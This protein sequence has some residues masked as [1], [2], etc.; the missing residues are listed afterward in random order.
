[1]SPVK[2][3]LV[4]VQPISAAQPGRRRSLQAAA[5]WAWPWPLPFTLGGCAVWPDADHAGPH[6][7]QAL[8]LRQAPRVAWVLGSGGPRGFVHVGVLKALHELGLKPDVIVGASVGA[9]VGALWASGMAMVTL[10]ALALEVQPLAVARLAVGEQA[11]FSGAVLADFIRWHVGALAPERMLQDLP[12][13]MACVAVRQRDDSLVAFTAGDV[14]VAVQASAAMPGL[15]TPV[16]I[17]GDLHVDPD[18]VAPLPVRVARALGAQR[19]LA[20]DASAH[21]GN[22]PPGA[23][24]FHASDRRKRALIEPDAHAADLVLQ[25]DFGYWVSL[26]REFRERAIAA[27]YH[28]TLARAADV[29]ALHAA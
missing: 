23:T 7:P 22:A 10:E 3:G 12:V 21:E 19:V 5:A 15:F 24:R 4:S 9:M 28:S 13:A 25:P 18:A 27:G 20:V 2:P 16:R 17:H 14:G 26:T 6:A 8:P 29:R 11:R 1:M